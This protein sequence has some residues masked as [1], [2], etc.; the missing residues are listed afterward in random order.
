MIEPVMMATPPAQED[1]PLEELTCCDGCRRRVV[2]E[3]PYQTQPLRNK[4]KESGGGSNEAVLP[5][6][7]VGN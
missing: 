1:E 6:A 3:V 5:G 7:V 2:P 4:T